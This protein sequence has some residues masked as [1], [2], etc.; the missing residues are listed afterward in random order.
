MAETCYM[1]VAP[2]NPLGPVANAAALHFALSTPNFLIQEDLLSD[3]PWRWDV[4]QHDLKTQDGFRLPVEIA[5]P[6]RGGQ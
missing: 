4:V 3:A 2:H 5:R 1:G 6:W